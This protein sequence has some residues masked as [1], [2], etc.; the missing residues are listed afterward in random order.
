MKALPATVLVLSLFISDVATASPTRSFAPSD[1]FALHRAGDARVSPDGR[2]VA[3]V[4][5]SSDIGIDGDRNDIVLVGV[6]DQRARVI[7]RSAGMPRWSPD[8]ATLAYVVNGTHVVVQSIAGG[9]TTSFDV[10][11]GVATLAWSPDGRRLAY[12]SFVAEPVATYV[13]PVTKPAGAAW[14]GPPRIID[15]APYQQDGQHGFEAGHL[16]LFVVRADGTGRRQLTFS[17]TDVDGDPV[18][19]R[20]GGALVYS[21]QPAAF[22]DHVYTKSR[23][24]RID[25]GGSA[26]VAISPAGIGARSP[27]ISPDGRTIAFVGTRPMERDY[28]PSTLYLMDADGRNERTLAASADAALGGPVFTPDGRAVLAILPDQGTTV[29]R[30]FDLDGTSRDLVRS[31]GG[32]GGFTVAS[33]GTVSFLTGS[34]DHPADVGIVEPSGRIRVLTSLNDELLRNRRL[35]TIRAFPFRSSLDGT[36][37][38][39]W[40]VCPSSVACHDLPLILMI[41]GGPYGYD[42]PTWSAEDQLLAAAG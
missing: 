6:V 8:G 42:D 27:A 1:L 9:M 19:T 35:A 37:I 5:S 13:P 38:G 15:G 31:V 40:L 14:A 22:R 7:A 24:F 34:F 20:D 29:L 36:R 41:H 33:S 17:G 26:P 39:A 21:A 12:T 30:R 4:R 11:G 25:A 2:H 3:Y 23:L 32:D 16:Q 10:A 28:A 18:W